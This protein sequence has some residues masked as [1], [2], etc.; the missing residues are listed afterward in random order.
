MCVNQPFARCIF[1]LPRFFVC[2]FTQNPR[3]PGSSLEQRA[4]QFRRPCNRKHIF[5]LTSAVVMP[6]GKFTA[7]NPQRLPCDL[8]SICVV[9]QSMQRR[10]TNR[11]PLWVACSTNYKRRQ[12]TANRNN[13]F[14]HVPAPP[15]SPRLILGHGRRQYIIHTIQLYHTW[16]VYIYPGC[17]SHPFP[18]GEWCGFGGVTRNILFN[19]YPTQL[20]L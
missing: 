13:Q 6:R 8:S 15:P 18:S 2:V 4:G 7:I 10:S 11:T 17:S 3:T 20:F 12:Q 5:T 14:S 19:D 1:L 9:N 16:L